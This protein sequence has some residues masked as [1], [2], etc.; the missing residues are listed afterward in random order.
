[1]TGAPVY[2]VKNRA[3][4]LYAGKVGSTWVANVKD[5]M[6]YD[7]F[8]SAK[9]AADIASMHLEVECVVEVV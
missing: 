5:A 9:L 7:K 3:R 2:V 8:T 6:Q 4:G 1:M